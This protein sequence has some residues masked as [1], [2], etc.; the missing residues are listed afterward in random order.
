MQ[1]CVSRRWNRTGN[2]QRYECHKDPGGVTKTANPSP[3]LSFSSTI[4][5]AAATTPY[6]ILILICFPPSSKRSAAAASLI[7]ALLPQRQP[8][9]P[10][11]LYLVLCLPAKL[12]GLLSSLFITCPY[13]FNSASHLLLQWRLCQLLLWCLHFWVFSLIF[14]VSD[15]ISL[16]FLALF[17]PPHPR[18]ILRYHLS[19]HG[20]LDLQ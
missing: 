17:P 1:C 7:D 16:L 14:P 8:P 20:R 19:R 12:T 9:S 11:C 18:I 5:K 3:S 10:A 15:A 2:K 13:H 4:L 6:S